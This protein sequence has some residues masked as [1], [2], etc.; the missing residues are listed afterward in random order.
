MQ[1]I[2]FSKLLGINWVGW[3]WGGGGFG[4]PNKGKTTMHGLVPFFSAQRF[5][6]FVCWLVFDPPPPK[7]PLLGYR[8][9]IVMHPH[10]QAK[11]W[12]SYIRLSYAVVEY[13]NTSVSCLG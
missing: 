1:D 8:L 12:Y 11:N 13:R 2:L 5:V 4:C 9:Y 6:L 3:G 10:K 7:T